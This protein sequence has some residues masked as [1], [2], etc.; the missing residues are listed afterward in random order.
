MFLLA[1]YSLIL[2]FTRLKYLNIK[3]IISLKDGEVVPLER[4]RTRPRAMARINQLLDEKLPAREIA[5]VY[6]TEISEAEEIVGRLGERLPEQRIY[7]A[8]FGPVLKVV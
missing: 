2:V 1:S 3:P 8:R 6:N 7:L 5:I 4:V